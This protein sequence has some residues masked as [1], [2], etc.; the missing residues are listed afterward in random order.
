MERIPI[1]EEGVR[2]YLDK[3]IIYWSSIHTNHLDEETK[4]MAKHYTEALQSVRMSLL[5]SA[6]VGYLIDPNTKLPVVENVDLTD[7]D[8][9]VDGV[10]H[11]MRSSIINLAKHPALYRYG[12]MGVDTY[13]WVL[14]AK[15]LVLLKAPHMRHVVDKIPSGGNTSNE[16]LTQITQILFSLIGSPEEIYKQW[17]GER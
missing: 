14:L 5:G 2:D 12:M 3:A 11:A 10:T 9:L 8:V 15:G 16:D 4:A 17:Q 7:V 1:T 13:D 6:L